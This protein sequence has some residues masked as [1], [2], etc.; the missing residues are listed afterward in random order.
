[1][2]KVHVMAFDKPIV[3]RVNPFRRMLLFLLIFGLIVLGPVATYYA[4]VGVLGR[5]NVEIAESLAE[6]SSLIDSLSSEVKELKQINENTHLSFEVDQYSLEN[7]RQ[8]MIVSERQIEFLNEQIVFYQSL[9][10]PDPGKAGVYIEKAEIKADVS[11]AGRYQYHLIIAQRSP[12]HEKIT[13][14]VEIEFISRDNSDASQTLLLRSLTEEAD[15][16]PLEFKFFQALEG[17]LLLPEGFS[18]DK[19][20]VLV[21]LNGQSTPSLD[22]IYEWNL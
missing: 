19:Y 8:E 11:V 17:G 14:Q 1:M 4:T 6:K 2:K 21:T 5:E 3:V 15:P 20:R 13:G 16:L 10:N 7:M 22:K 12:N 9:M 18:P